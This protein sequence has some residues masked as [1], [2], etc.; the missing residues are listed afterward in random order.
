MRLFQPDRIPATVNRGR[1]EL[2]TADELI[3]LCRGLLADGHVNA[4][5]AKFLANWIAKNRDIHD[6]ELVVALFARIDEAL[7]DGVID[8]EEESDL[9]AALHGYIGGEASQASWLPLDTPAPSLVFPGCTFVVTGTFAIGPRKLVS[10]E[11]E[12][13]GGTVSDSVRTT[14]NVLVIGDTASRDWVHSSYGRKI[15]AA[16]DFREEGYP[17]AIVSEGHWKL[18]L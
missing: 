9:L 5:E 16:V 7:I 3:G 11:I 15:M 8:P 13:R 14:T 17:I 6:D 18:H 2:R 10:A 4:D 1:R 12:S